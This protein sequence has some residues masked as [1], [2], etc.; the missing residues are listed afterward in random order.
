[1]TKITTL[2]IDPGIN[3]TGVAIVEYSDDFR[4]LEHKEFNHNNKKDNY[5]NIANI[6]SQYNRQINDYVNNRYDIA[7]IEAV[8][9][10]GERSHHATLNKLA[11]IAG[12][13]TAT[14]EATPVE[15]REWKKITG[16]ANASKKYIKKFVDTMYDNIKSQHV[17]DAICIAMYGILHNNVN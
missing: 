16:K 11:F 12:Y 8:E 4:L 10:H 15:P 6:A 9:Y 7:I 14:L 13:L 5:Q 17:A 3:H 1:M 2:G